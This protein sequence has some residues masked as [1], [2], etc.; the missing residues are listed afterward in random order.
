MLRSELSVAGLCSMD[1]VQQAA[2]QTQTDEA[3]DEFDSE[4]AECD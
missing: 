4:A 1:S 2:Q 3:A